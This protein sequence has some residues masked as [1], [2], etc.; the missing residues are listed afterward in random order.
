MKKHKHDD[1]MK[2]NGIY[3]S[4]VS[5]RKEAVGWKI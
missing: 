5:D 1:L 4:F 2:E 3:K